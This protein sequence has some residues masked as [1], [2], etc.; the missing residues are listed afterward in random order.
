M[1]SS[2]TGL[3]WTQFWTYSQLFV[4]GLS[5]PAVQMRFCLAIQQ[6][7]WLKFLIILRQQWKDA[8]YYDT[9]EMERYPWQ[10]WF[11]ADCRLPKEEFYQFIWRPRPPSKLSKEQ[12]EDILK[13]L[14]KYSKKYDEED[15]KIMNAVS[16]DS[17]FRVLKGTV[18]A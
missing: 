13:N 9:S 3:N 15:A 1:A 2:F 7:S 17:A 6:I 8:I 18:S 5:L 12:E 10:E 11:I 14:K 16:L 4:L